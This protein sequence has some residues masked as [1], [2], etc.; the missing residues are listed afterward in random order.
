MMNTIIDPFVSGALLRLTKSEL[1]EQVLW[2]RAKA[3]DLDQR[4]E[5]SDRERGAMYVQRQIK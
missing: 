2:L 1:V 3:L 4:R 5:Q